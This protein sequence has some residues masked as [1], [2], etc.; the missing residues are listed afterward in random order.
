MTIL[1]NILILIIIIFIFIIYLSNNTISK[2]KKDNKKLNIDLLHYKY[3]LNNINYEK[4]LL[5]KEKKLISNL[6]LNN[7]IASNKVIIYSTNLNILKYSRNILIKLG[8]IV[9]LVDNEYDLLR[10]VGEIDNYNL[11]L[12]DHKVNNNKINTYIKEELNLNIPIIIIGK[13]IKEN[14]NKKDIDNFIW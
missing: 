10:K 1:E 12:I 4:E 5:L 3:E 9:D 2:L 13:D 14:F 7:I 8:F 11:I 6:E